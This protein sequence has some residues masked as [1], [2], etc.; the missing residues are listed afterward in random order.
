MDGETPEQTSSL[1]EDGLK[2]TAD[3]FDKLAEE[4]LGGK[5]KDKDDKESENGD[6]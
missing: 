4:I 3:Y 2:Y 5:D 1:K 6:D